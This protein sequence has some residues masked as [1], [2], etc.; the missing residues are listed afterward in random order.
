MMQHYPNTK[1]Q[2]YC[3]I[4]KLQTNSSYTHR[5][6]Y[7]QKTTKKMNQQCGKTSTLQPSG[8]SPSYARL[9]PHPKSNAIC[10]I[11]G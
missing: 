10:Y 6:K 8:S 5:G 2:I 1:V 7:P 3:K 11:T 4:G 9:I